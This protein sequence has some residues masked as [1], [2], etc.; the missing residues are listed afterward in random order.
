MTKELQIVVLSALMHDIGKFAQRAKRPYSKAME[1][2][3]LTNYKGKPGHWHTVYSDYFLENDLPLPEELENFR[4]VIARTASAHH[5]PDT[6][7]LV[8]M[9]I[10]IADRLSSGSDRIE[11]R[12]NEGKTGFRESRL[13][14]IFDEIELYN[15]TFQ[16]AKSWYY[17]LAALES[18]GANIFPIQGKPVGRAEEYIELFEKFHNE[19]ININNGMAFPFYFETLISIMEKYTWSIPSSS[20]NTLSD[21]SLFDHSFSTACIAQALYVYHSHTGDL[22]DWKDDREK[23]ILLG[24]DLSGI[25]NY[26]FGISKNSGR[27]VS[28][29]FRARSFYLQV[30]TRSVLLE[31]QNRLNLFSVFRLVDSGGKFILLLPT[32]ENIIKEIE[33]IDEEIQIF[34]MNK[35]KGLLTMNISWSTMISQQGLHLANFQDSID[36]VNE[37]IEECKLKKL[38]KAILK[39]GPVINTDYDER[40]GGNCSLCSINSADDKSSSKYEEKESISVPVCKDC[41]EQIIYIGT[42]L[43]KTNYLIYGSNCRIPLFGKTSLTLSVNAPTDF[44][45]I[46]HI[47]S[48]ADTGRFSRARIARHLPEVTSEELKNEKWFNLFAKE[49]GFSEQV[50]K[51]E[52]NGDYLSKTFNM[53]AQKSK[54]TDSKGE[55]TGRAL[56]SF[57]KAD[58][59]N[60][61]LIFSIGLGNK[62]SVARLASLS[63]MINLFFSEYLVKLLRNQYPD[64]YVVFAGGDDLFL[65]GPWRQTVNCSIELRKQM[66]RFCAMNQDITLSCGILTGRPRLPMRKAAEITEEQLEKAKNNKADNRIKD[67]VTFY[68]EVMSWEEFEELLKTGEKFDKAIEEKERTHFSAAF[69]YRLLEYHRMYRRFIAG[70]DIKAGRYISSAHY[71]IARNI[72]INKHE[73]DK[74][75]EMLYEIF[76]VDS[77]DRSKINLLNIPLF[78]AINLN[79]KTN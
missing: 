4:S 8:E 68:G 57:L 34:F 11:L 48:I 47:E 71:D 5:K 60:L 15:H 43:P 3:Y 65:I 22:P 75:L 39:N 26:I 78:Y 66:G 2:E 62:L 12:D 41:C 23:F 24:G 28:K 40:E 10:T 59:D 70:A 38:S 37:A 72:R 9:C 16:P 25:Q 6:Q 46:S 29:I 30:L 58:V 17:N 53:I 77:A 79:R 19:I 36:A 14:S 18:D 73:N 54:K 32:T 76:A 20:Y 1:G 35:F 52:Q 61:G 55:L 63:R 50:A 31:L 21:I 69:L 44:K 27:G 56:L 45:N 64:I 42:R 74:E 33:K 67:S 13:I 51:I 7:N 49:E